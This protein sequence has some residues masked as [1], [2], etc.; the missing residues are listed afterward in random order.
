M[1]E[2]AVAIDPASVRVCHTVDGLQRSMLA[3]RFD[4]SGKYLL[5]GG[6]MPHVV[7]Y[8]LPVEGEA[9]AWDQKGTLL[10]LNGHK[11]WVAALDVA[12]D[13]GRFFSADYSGQLCGWSFPAASPEDKPLWSQQAHQGWVRALAVSPD[14]SQ[15]ATCGNDHAVRLWSPDDGSLIRELAGHTCHVYNL[16]FH[17]T[18]DYLVSG[19]L[20]GNVIQWDLLT[21]KPV[22]QQLAKNTYTRRDN[23]QLGGIR[24]MNFSSDGYL[25]GCGGMFG[26]GSIGDG[27]GSPSVTVFEFE[28]DEARRRLTSKEQ[29]RSFVNGVHFHS[30]G[31]TIAATGGLDGGTLL[32]WNEEAG[33][34][35]IKSLHHHALK[36][37]GWGMDVHPDE[38]HV[39]VA[40]HDGY[41]NVYDLS[42]AEKPAS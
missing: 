31:L 38:V 37:S 28:A 22:R 40:H 2:E 20:E 34:S 3:C 21:G 19:D 33:E 11:T 6:M 26:I 18:L 12:P 1:S 7:Q 9:I 10:R 8:A 27:I 41:V 24:C 14:G 42:P 16:A 36:S 32:F 35:P 29:H 39:A 5:A 15:V 23:L 25:L 17:P 30:S 4:P 13:G